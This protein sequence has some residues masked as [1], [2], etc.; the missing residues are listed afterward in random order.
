MKVVMLTGSLQ[1]GGAQRQM[2]EL[3]CCLASKGL[4]PTVVALNDKGPLGEELHDRQLEVV[5]LD[6]GSRWRQLRR[7]LASLNPQIVQ[8]WGDTANLWGGLRT[9]KGVPLIMSWRNLG[10]RKP[11]TRTL[12]E[13][14]LVGRAQAHV[15]NAEAV[16]VQLRRRGFPEEKIRVIHNG[17]DTDTFAPPSD[18]EKSAARASLGLPE[19]AKVV[20]TIGRTDPVK[21]LSLLVDIAARVCRHMPKAKFVIVGGPANEREA[22]EAKRIAECIAAAHLQDNFEVLGMRQDVPTCLQAAD[23][24]VQTSDKEG[25]PN[26]LIEAAACGLPVVA[27][28]VG[29]T[30]EVVATGLTGFLFPE[31]N[32]QAGINAISKVLVDGE[33]ASEMGASARKHVSQ[34]FGMDAMTRAFLNLYQESHR[35]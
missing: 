19:D 14:L 30:P 29:G 6:K 34:R 32:R 4:S 11:W 3:A 22:K 28:D 10:H 5:R 16:A 21:N 26:S 12:A 35:K 13:K 7:C 20:M 9:V 2:I 17:I 18:E 23:V 27:T 33:L 25:L 31:G 8:S 1:I 15:A 24:V